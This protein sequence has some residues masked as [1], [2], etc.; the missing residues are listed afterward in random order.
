M[1]R[2]RQWDHRFTTAKPS[3]ELILGKLHGALPWGWE[4]IIGQILGPSS[5]LRHISP[6][7]TS[8]QPPQ[9]LPNTLAQLGH[10]DTWH[11]ATD[12]TQFPLTEAP[13]TSRDSD[14]RS[15]VR[16]SQSRMPPVLRNLVWLSQARKHKSHPWDPVGPSEQEHLET[17]IR[18]G[19][20]RDTHPRPDGPL[21]SFLASARPTRMSLRTRVEPSR[22]DSSAT[23]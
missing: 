7:V 3:P 12:L 2:P 23:V 1:A 11:S 5:Q 8:P 4:R 10:I 20:S 17:H 16:L 9:L 6:R 19:A 15:V 21:S 13:G 14:R 22:V 18:V